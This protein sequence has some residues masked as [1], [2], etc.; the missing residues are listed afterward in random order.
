VKSYSQNEQRPR[1]TQSMA[2]PKSYEGENISHQA[3]FRVLNGIMVHFREGGNVSYIRFP[4]DIIIQL[5]N[6]PLNVT[7]LGLS[8][9]LQPLGFRYSGSNILIHE[10]EKNSASA[11]VQ[12]E[13]V[14]VAE[15]GCS[16]STKHFW[17]ITKSPR[18]LYEIRAKAK[19]LRADYNSPLLLVPGTNPLDKDGRH[20]M[21]K[22]R[23]SG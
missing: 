20:S 11:E 12:V 21:M 6:L 5:S 4:S 15:F 19:Q 14:L 3:C 8:E 13:D 17:K 7:C 1:Q 16:C 9:L 10:R 22:Q 18:N 2:Q 23:R